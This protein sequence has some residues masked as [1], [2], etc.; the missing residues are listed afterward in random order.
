M[1]DSLKKAQ[2]NYR[3]KCKIYQ[4]RVNKETEGDVADWLEQ[5]NTAARLKQLIRQDIKN[6]PRK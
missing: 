4:F 2:E 1:R 3:K 5:G 6:T